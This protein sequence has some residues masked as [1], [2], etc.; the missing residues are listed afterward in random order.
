MVRAT[1][2]RALATVCLSLAGVSACSSD[3]G[4]EPGVAAQEVCATKHKSFDVANTKYFHVF[5]S[6]A[7]AVQALRTGFNNY[8]WLDPGSALQR[9]G[10]AAAAKAYAAFQKIYPEATQDM[11]GPPRIMMIDDPNINAFA[12]STPIITEADGRRTA[13]WIFTYFSGIFSDGMSDARIELVAAHELAHLLLRNGNPDVFKPI[14]YR[15]STGEQGKIFGAYEPSEPLIEGHVNLIQDIGSRIGQVV[16]PQLNGFPTPYLG[17]SFMEDKKALPAYL[18]YLGYLHAA[19]SSASTN[20][21]ACTQAAAAYSEV[22]QTVRA[23]KTDDLDVDLG[24][25][26]GKLDTATKRYAS[27]EASCLAHVKATFREVVI[28]AKREMREDPDAA[29]TLAK[30]GNNEAQLR[31]YLGLSQVEVEADEAD[32]QGSPSNIVTKILKLGAIAQT[33]LRAHFADP[34]FKYQ[35]LRIYT[36]ED[37]ADEAAVRV[38]K[39]LG[40]NADDL[41]EALMLD[42]PDYA[43]HCR[44]LI[45]RD[46]VPPYGGAIDD[47]HT[48]CWRS[49]RNAKLASSLE[50]CGANWP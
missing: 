42:N 10:E 22:L 28:Y 14:Y 40:L 34:T 35:E 3:G 2:A 31:R 8:K 24:A 49:Y 30:I 1:T 48:A 9:R 44:D 29:K 43:T 41:G 12:I 13:P 4:T 27:A 38:A 11:P 26:A 5:E 23:H 46:Q 36:R 45:A 19:Q 21:A 16:V 47:H 7:A 6:D 32:P 20:K 37:E 25:D 33:R 39:V 17:T 50:T 15:E 18:R